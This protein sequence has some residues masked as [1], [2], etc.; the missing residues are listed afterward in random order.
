MHKSN[1]NF[2]KRNFCL[3]S[4]QTLITTDCEVVLMT[5][6]LEHGFI[7]VFYRRL[8]NNVPELSIYNLI[9]EVKSIGELLIPICIKL[10]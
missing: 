4:S 1:T 2:G 9:S 10:S 5:V 6:D 3:I 8:W 7:K